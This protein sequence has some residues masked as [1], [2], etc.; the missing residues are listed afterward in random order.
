M[1]TELGFRKFKDSDAKQLAKIGNNKN[2]A[3]NMRDMFP[4]PYTL[5]DAKAFIQ[6]ANEDTPGRHVI[7]ITLNDEVIGS[8][9]GFAESDI[10]SKNMEVGYWLGEEYWHQGYATQAVQWLINYLLEHTEV[11]RL[12]AGVFEYNIASANVLEKCGFRRIAR[13]R[14]KVYKN[15]AF[16]D[17]FL[18]DLLREDLE[19]I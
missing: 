8:M 10:Y 6:K 11:N 4:H 2:I 3:R 1:K 9:G 12:F 15:G 5:S 13:V 14:Q 7:A 19:Q 16:Y 17:E 18:F